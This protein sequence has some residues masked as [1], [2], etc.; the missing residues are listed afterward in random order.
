VAEDDGTSIDSETVPTGT[1]ISKAGDKL[2]LP[3][4]TPTATPSTTP[5]P[6][7]TPTTTSTPKPVAPPPV[8]ESACPPG[9]QITA[10]IEGAR[11]TQRY[12]Y[13]LG[14]ANIPRFHHWRIEYSTNPNG[15]WNHLLERDYPVDN[16]KL[17]M[18]DARTVPRGPYGLRLTVVDETGNYPEPCE[19]WFI[20]AY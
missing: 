15:G 6:T 2:A 20:N 16:D 3:S 5:T 17:M 13:I 14:I 19:V 1:P 12:N 8:A 10:P 11:F 7:S 18:L 4:S 9:A